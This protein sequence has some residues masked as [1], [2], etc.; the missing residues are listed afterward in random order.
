M[1][2]RA[3][4]ASPWRFSIPFLGKR[5]TKVHPGGMIGKSDRAS[6][7]ENVKTQSDAVDPFKVSGISFR[8]NIITG[9]VESR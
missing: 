7:N 5:S 6:T 8:K 3:T 1:S 4:T 9:V 2:Y